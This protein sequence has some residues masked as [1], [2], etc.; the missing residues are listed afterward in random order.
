MA[1]DIDLVVDL[2]I[3]DLSPLLSR[4]KHHYVLDE[5]ALQEAVRQQIACSLIHLDTLMKVDLVVAKREAFDTALRQQVVSFQLD[6]RYPPLLIASAEEMILVKARRYSQDLLSRTDGM[7]DDAEWN[8]I[9]GMLKVQGPTLERKL[10]EDWARILQ[11]TET[12]G[13]ALVDAGLE[14]EKAA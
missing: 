8:D 7:R 4:L 2:Q 12:L 9:V 10:L 11:I 1:H 13:Q 14:Q 3:H 5:N 6:E